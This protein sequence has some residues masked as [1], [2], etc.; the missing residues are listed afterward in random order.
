MQWEDSQSTRSQSLT[1]KLYNLGFT[2]GGS[3][4][5]GVLDEDNM[6][7]N[8]NTKLA[9]QQSI[10][11][12]VDVQNAAQAINFQGDTGGNQSVTINTEVLNI[13]GGTGLDTVGSSNTVTIN[14]DNTV[15]TLTGTQTLTNKTLT[16]PVLNSVDLNGG[17]ISSG[18]VINLSLIHI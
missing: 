2:S 5:T 3:V 9:T 10:K 11:S 1:A 12:Y 16:S 18:T 13:T 15:T 8:S 4:V 14:I 17:D 7:S 6:G